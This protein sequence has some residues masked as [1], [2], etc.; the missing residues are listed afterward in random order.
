[1]G[2]TDDIFHA[3]PKSVDG[4]ATKF[5]QWSTKVGGDGKS[6]QW[7]KMPGDYGGKTGV[8]EYSKGVD[9]LINH[10]FFN[11]SKAP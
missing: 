1:M 11:V 7:L 4:Y 2:K 8:F 9:G 3:F 5:G 10:R 6:Y